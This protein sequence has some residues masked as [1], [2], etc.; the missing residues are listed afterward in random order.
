M[1][2]FAMVNSSAPPATGDSAAQSTA[3]KKTPTKRRK[4]KK[5]SLGAIKKLTK[6][7]KS[8]RDAQHAAGELADHL[9]LFVHKLER[10]LTPA[11]SQPAGQGSEIGAEPEKKRKPE[12]TDDDGVQKKK[13]TKK[14]SSAQATQPVK[15][16]EPATKPMSASEPV[17]TAEPEHIEAEPEKKKKKK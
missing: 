16:P 15:A 7:T 2:R 10:S 4:L 6:M 9:E 12:N 17:R 1:G 14:T 11:T 3:V 5:I 8:C 13:D